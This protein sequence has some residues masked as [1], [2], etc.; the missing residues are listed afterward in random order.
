MQIA[1]RTAWQSL[2]YSPLDTVVSPLANNCEAPFTLEINFESVF[3]IFVHLAYWHSETDWNITS[4]I[5]AG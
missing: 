1:T 4:L 2:A 3:T 5:L